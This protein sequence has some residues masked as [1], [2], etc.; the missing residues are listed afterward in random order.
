MKDKYSREYL[1]RKWQEYSFV[2]YEARLYLDTHPDSR[3]AL[4]CFNKFNALQLAA[5]R[6]LQN[7]YGAVNTNLDMPLAEWSWTA[8]PWPWTEEEGGN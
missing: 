3:S 4:N 5:A 8:M 2:A 1:M 6:E 7:R